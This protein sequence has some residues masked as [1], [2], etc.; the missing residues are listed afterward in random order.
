MGYYF[1][2]FHFSD[3]TPFETHVGH[4]DCQQ[5]KTKAQHGLPGFW[6]LPTGKSEENHEMPVK[7]I[8][9][10]YLFCWAWGS[11]TIQSHK[12]THNWLIW[13]GMFPIYFYITFSA[14][15]SALIL[16]LDKTTHILLQKCK[17]LRACFQSHN[18]I[19]M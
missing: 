15:Q 5:N 3:S 9:F 13:V 19:F 10:A 16:H 12:L 14:L 7:A 4:H 8:W 17:I 6:T 18:N 11:Q 1:W 2:I